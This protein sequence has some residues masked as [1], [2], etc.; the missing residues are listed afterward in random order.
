M[1]TDFS[2]SRNSLA[3]IAL[4]N[5]YCHTIEHASE[6]VRDTFISSLLKILPR[7]YIA[8]TDINM[9]TEEDSDID[10]ISPSLDEA[11][12]NIIKDT[13]ATLFADE[14]VYLEVFEED[15]KFSDSP[16]ANSI[17]ENLADIYQQLFDFVAAIEDVTPIIAN[18]VVSSLKDTFSSFWGQSLLNVL[19]ALH[20]IKF[21]HTI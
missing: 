9:K 21:N 14:D 13:L 2:L 8:T 10:L 12:Y 15:M 11:S 19:R 6:S 4:A 17:S 5:E 18:H 20:N 3:L 1:D 7:I 16:I